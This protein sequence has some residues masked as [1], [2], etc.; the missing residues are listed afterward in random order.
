MYAPGAWSSG[1]SYGHL[2]Y[3]TFAG[4]ANSMMVYAISD[5]SANHNPGPVTKGLLKDLGWVLAGETTG[6]TIYLPL[7]LRDFSGSLPGNFSKS[8]PA[9]DATGQPANPTLSWGASSNANS[10]EYCIDIS[11]NGACDATWTSTAASTSVGLSGL[12]PAN[13]Y[14]QV[15]ANNASGT[16]NADGG[17]WWSFTI[18]GSPTP[19]GPTPAG[20]TPTG[21]TAGFWESTTGDE[22]YVTPDQSNVDDFAIYVDVTG[23]GSWKITHHTTEPIVGNQF[24]FNNGTFYASGTFD[25]TT[26]AHG[27]DGLYLFFIPD[28][29]FSVSGDWDWTATWKNS[30][31]PAA[32]TGGD[33]QSVILMP[34][35]PMPNYNHT[36]TIER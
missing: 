14:W 21:P 1:S 30:S 36:I 9:N 35:L 15:R 8:A 31:Q 18:A 17:T 34:A 29:L 19:A 2:D 33:V 3:S 13:Y 27:T 11:N 28:C 5:G 16:T 23:C 7:V 26:S 6:S 25:S 10:Y 24:S 32:V 4:T 22:F 12:T 20:P